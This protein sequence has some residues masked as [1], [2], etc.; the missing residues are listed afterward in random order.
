[1]R[2]TQLIKQHECPVRGKKCVKCGK[3][4][5][6]TK[7]CRSTRKMNN[8]A[9][10]KTY[11][12]DEGDWIPDRIHSIQQKINSKGT[13]SKDGPPFYIKTILVNNRPYKFIVGTGSPVKLFPKMKFNM[14]TTIK[15]VIE[16]Y[17]DVNDNNINSKVKQ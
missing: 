4:G 11:S 7:C 14:I 10:G 16:D 5:H 1:M 3:V 9:D 12:A 15:P 13:N 8:I 17:R 2:S 6:Y